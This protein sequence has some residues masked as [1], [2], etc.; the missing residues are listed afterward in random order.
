[1]VIE[2]SEKSLHTENFDSNLIGFDK[3]N[4]LSIFEKKISFLR[5]NSNFFEV[6]N[7][8]LVESKNIDLNEKKKNDFDNKNAK[9]LFQEVKSY[10]FNELKSLVFS[11]GNIPSVTLNFRR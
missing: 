6:L 3:Y 7:L 4:L 10:D 9:T 1:M 5:D 11:Q 2:F 8:S